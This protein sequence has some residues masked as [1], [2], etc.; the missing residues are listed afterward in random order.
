LSGRLFE[1]QNHWLIKRADTPNYYVYWC[2]QGTRRVR[3]KSTNTTDLEHAKRWLIEFAEK[4][5]RPSDQPPDDALILDALNDYVELDMAGRASEKNSRSSL[6][7]WSRFL[8]LWDVCYTSELTLDLQDEFVEWRRE[9][10]ISPRGEPSNAAIL[11]DIAVLSAALNRMVIR[12]KLA[13]APYIQRIPPPPPRDRYLSL[14]ELDRLFNA[15]DEP[16]LLL[17]V[18]LALHTVQRPGAIFKLRT[19]RVFLER[20]RIDFR[21]PREA[22][23][24]KRK[25]AVRIGDV[26]HEI[27]SKAI[28][29]SQSGFVVEYR[30]EPICGVRRSFRE[31]CIR[32]GLG[33]DVIPYTLRHTGA[34]L[35][36]AN[37]VPL[38]QLS[39]ML[40]HSL[41]R[42]TEIYA[43]HCPEFMQEATDTTDRLYSNLG[44]GSFAHQTRANQDDLKKCLA[45]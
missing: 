39:G 14:D 22:T 38:W 32:A 44:T 17:F 13:Q 29:Q 42:T 28:E 23:T 3:R 4:K 1:Y 11:R 35:L 20:R 41:Q 12:R 18:Q 34:T 15:C 8:S 40:G 2:K 10:M 27:L 24:N 5:R 26:L 30:G 7:I 45:A 16:H 21:L 19:D 36:A 6:R 43:K 9:T 37:G 25:A 31:A 33:D